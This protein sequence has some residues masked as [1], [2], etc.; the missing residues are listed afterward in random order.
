MEDTCLSDSVS[1]IY[2][3]EI[4]MLSDFDY[5]PYGLE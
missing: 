5:Y 2:S 3:E 4:G 1:I